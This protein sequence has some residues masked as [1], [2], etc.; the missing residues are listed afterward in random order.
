VLLEN[1]KFCICLIILQEESPPPPKYKL[2]CK[3]NSWSYRYSESCSLYRRDKLCIFIS[4]CWIHE[5]IREAD[6]KTFVCCIFNP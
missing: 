6:F 4:Q 5:K 2:D 1:E 3:W